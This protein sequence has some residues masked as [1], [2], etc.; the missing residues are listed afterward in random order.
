MRSIINIFLIH[1]NVQYIRRTLQ[2]SFMARERGLVRHIGG[3]LTYWTPLSQYVILWFIS[4][5]Y[6]LKVTRGQRL[7]DVQYHYHVR[8]CGRVQV[9]T[10]VSLS[11]GCPSRTKFWSSD[12][13]FA[14]KLNLG[15]DKFKLFF[16]N[17]LTSGR[18][19]KKLLSYSGQGSTLVESRRMTWKIL[20][21]RDTLTFMYAFLERKYFNFMLVNFP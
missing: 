20:F 14:P 12:F 8:S 13:C 6:D 21:Q 5:T 4:L 9:Q 17:F 1:P 10:W 7:I 16:Q 15:L 11:L 18:F 2:S 19:R 3:W